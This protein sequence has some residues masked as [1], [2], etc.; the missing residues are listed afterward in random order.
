M[1]YQL[2]FFII[3][4]SVYSIIVTTFLIELKIKVNKLEIDLSE[5]PPLY[6]P[7]DTFHEITKN[8]YEIIIP[9]MSILCVDSDGKGFIT[10]AVNPTYGQ[11]NWLIK[12]KKNDKLAIRKIK[13]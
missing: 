11:M 13:T 6:N 10:F 3:I 4:L 5:A 8:T 7:I 9:P 2:F 12:L 1:N